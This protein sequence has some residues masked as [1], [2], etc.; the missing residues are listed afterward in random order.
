MSFFFVVSSENLHQL[1]PLNFTV[2]TDSVDFS[3]IDD[4]DLLYIIIT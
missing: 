4:L 3:P 1:E 2:F